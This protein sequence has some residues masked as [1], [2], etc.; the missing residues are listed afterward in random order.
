MGARRPGC[1]RISSDVVL[2]NLNG[3][4]AALLAAPA[5]P[6]MHDWITASA[7]PAESSWWFTLGIILKVSEPTTA[8]MTD[9]EGRFRFPHLKVGPRAVRPIPIASPPSAG[10]RRHD[11]QAPDSR[12]SR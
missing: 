6:T 2:V 5:T 3:Q 11:A 9:R 7:Y 4:I 8:V 12:R 10:L 1:V